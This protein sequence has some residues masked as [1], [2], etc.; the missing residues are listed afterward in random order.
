MTDEINFTDE[1]PLPMPRPEE[2]QLETFIDN[3]DMEEA[4]AESLRSITR[5]LVGGA[6]VGWDELFSHLRAWEEE[7][8]ATRAQEADVINAPP[9]DPATT[10]RFAM[11]GLLFESQERVVKRSKKTLDLV[12]QVTESFWSPFLNR[13]ANARQLD[14][15]RDRYENL[16]RRGEAVTRGWV[17]RGQDEEARSRQLART[18]VQESFD[19]SMEE[20]GQAPALEQLI[21]RQSAGLTQTAM[22][23]ARARTISGDLIAEH[24]ARRIL[25]RVPRNQLQEPTPADE[26]ES[27]SSESG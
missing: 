27:G 22:D 18:A 9:Q 4:D 16:V 12:W 8:T 5:L 24:F 21:R 14:P 2:D 10:M 3:M 25:R 1:G 19:T 15:A 13:A 20:L 6:L 11:I 26:S 7:I 23:E 17:D